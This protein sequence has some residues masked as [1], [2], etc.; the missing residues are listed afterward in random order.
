MNEMSYL[1]EKNVPMP[2]G[3]MSS[4]TG[5]FRGMAVGDSVVLPKRPTGGTFIRLKPAK[6]ATRTVEGGFRIWRLV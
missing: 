3:Q 1:I 4:L 6:Y 2:I 5:L